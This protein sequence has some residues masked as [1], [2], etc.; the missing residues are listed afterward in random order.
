MSGTT[1]FSLPFRPSAVGPFSLLVPGTVLGL[2]APA[3]AVLLGK[4]THDNERST[5]LCGLPSSPRARSHVDYGGWMVGTL[6][7]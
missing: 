1:A 4:R 7:Q 6:L 3:P 2:A 5:T